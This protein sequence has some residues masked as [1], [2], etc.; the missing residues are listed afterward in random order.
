MRLVK[1]LLERCVE[2][3]ERMAGAGP[4]RLSDLAHALELP[5]G[6]THRLLRELCALGWAEQDGTDGP[7]RLTLRFGLLGNRVLQASGLLDLTQPVLQQLASRTRELARL[8]VPAGEEL[9]WLASAQGAP[10]GLVYQPSMEGPLLLHATANG[11]AF[12]ATLPDAEALRLARRG[13]LG[14]RQPTPRTLADP[15][16]LLAALQDVR[17]RGYAVADQEAEFGVTAVAVAITPNGGPALGTVS[18]AGPSLRMPAARIP[19]LVAALREAAIA[20]ATV[21]PHR[22][23]A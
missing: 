18:V 15:A 6:A 17:T 3:T 7:Y 9:V 14:T 16:A 11:K 22:R 13:G 20:L 2:V 12:L 8:T 23:P 5:K 1:G 21:W 4:M 10:P 19:D